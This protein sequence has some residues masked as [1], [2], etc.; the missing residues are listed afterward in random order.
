MDACAV[1]PKL[2]HT[3]GEAADGNLCARRRAS[4]IY[5][6]RRTLLC[7][8]QGSSEPT[9][10]HVHV[11]FAQNSHCLQGG[12]VGGPPTRFKSSP[13]ARKTSASSGASARTT[14]ARRASPPRVEEAPHH[15]SVKEVAPFGSDQ[16][17]HLE[18]MRLTPSCRLSQHKQTPSAC[19]VARR[20]CAAG[21]N[22]TL[23]AYG[24]TGPQDPFGLGTAMTAAWA[25]ASSTADLRIDRRRHVGR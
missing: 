24:Q 6:L 8:R 20:C 21:Y 5:I 14:S 13:W 22:A 16:M 4:I 2:R 19:D 25:A 9:P 11:G 12:R 23:L 18:T 17:R 10:A 1:H 7:W 3:S 15:A